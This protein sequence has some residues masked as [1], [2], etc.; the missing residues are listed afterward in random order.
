MQTQETDYYKKQLQEKLAQLQATAKSQRTQA[1]NSHES[2]DFVG[3]DRAAELES[4]EVDTQI[5]DGSEN[6]AR[7]IQYALQ[8]IE[9]GTYGT[10]ESCGQDIPRERLQVKPS[11]SLCI[12]CQ[13][14]HETA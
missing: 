2:N 10:C 5:A 11:V 7:K 14:K 1:E 6:Y 12:P 4:M 9:D 13:E 8:R 3:G